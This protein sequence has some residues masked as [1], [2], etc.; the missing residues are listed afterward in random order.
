[1]PNSGHH[2]DA[3]VGAPGTTS[4]LCFKARGQCMWKT[5]ATGSE[6]SV[7]RLFKTFFTRSSMKA[8][9]RHLVSYPHFSFGDTIY[10]QTKS[11]PMGTNCAGF[12]ANLYLLTYELQFMQ[13]LT[14]LIVAGT[15]VDA[16][17]HGRHMGTIARG[18][19]LDFTFFG[20]YFFFLWSLT[21][22]L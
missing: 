1:M 19:F 12:L 18:L 11:I 7:R 22:C 17:P 4:V 15:C 3:H 8:A 14:S 13:Q 16:T 5:V 6:N 21:I 20:R 10:R 2:F 9:L